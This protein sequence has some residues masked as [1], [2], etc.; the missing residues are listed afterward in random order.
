VIILL[1]GPRQIGKSSVCYKLAQAAQARRL[2]VGGVLALAEF[3]A[4]GAKTDIW[5]LNLATGERRRQASA[6]EDLGGRRVGRYS[7]DDAVMAWG[8]DA[9]LRAIAGGSDLV[10][11]DEI[12]P[13]ELIA[14]AG[15]AAT[16]PALLAQPAVNAVVIVRPELVDELRRRLAGAALEVYF[17]SVANRDALPAELAGRL[18]DRA[19]SK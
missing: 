7:T 6:V 18:W 1:S 13:L 4:A 15:L 5:L 19:R 11:I 9:V 14:G 17:V 2:N 3:D 8:V 12:G 10:V 16:L